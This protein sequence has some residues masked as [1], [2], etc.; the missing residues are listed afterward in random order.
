ML[1]IDPRD[2]ETE[3]G[4]REFPFDERRA[5]DFEYFLSH[6]L[7]AALQDDLRLGDL[8]AGAR[9]VPAVGETSPVGGFDRQA[10]LVLAR[11]LGVPAVRF[12][13]GHNG[14]MTHPRAFAARLTEV[15]GA[16]VSPQWSREGHEPYRS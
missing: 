15:L 13:G 14:N 3:P 12:P 5:A 9:I 6:D 1:G 7:D 10:G 8:P 16:A 11:H 4:V 2:Q